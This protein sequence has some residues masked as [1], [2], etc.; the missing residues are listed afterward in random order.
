MTSSKNW[1]GT[2]DARLVFHLGAIEAALRLPSADSH[3]RD[4]RRLD[5]GVSPWREAAI[6]AL[7]GGAR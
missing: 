6:S 7:L 5:A 4:G 1:L 3:L 2:R